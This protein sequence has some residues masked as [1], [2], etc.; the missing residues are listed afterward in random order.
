MCLRM[1][2]FL[3]R[4]EMNIFPENRTCLEE[5]DSYMGYYRSSHSSMGQQSLISTLENTTKKEHSPFSCKK[6]VHESDTPHSKTSANDQAEGEELVIPGD[7]AEIADFIDTASVN[8]RIKLDLFL[9]SAS[10]VFPSKHMYEV[11]YN[12]YFPWLMLVL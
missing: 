4:L 9:P 1:N 5:N 10:L 7:K 8:T 6:V 11:L 3:N 12:R 2:I